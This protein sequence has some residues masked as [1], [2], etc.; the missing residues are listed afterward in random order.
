MNK[1]LIV[2]DSVV[3]IDSLRVEHKAL[4]TNVFGSGSTPTINVVF[5]S[6]DDT[7]TDNY[8]RQLERQTS[9][10]H[11]SVNSAKANCWR[12]TDES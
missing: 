2:G 8:G 3:F 4:V 1:D 9:T 5:A 11:V 12:H 10:C 7:K 6:G